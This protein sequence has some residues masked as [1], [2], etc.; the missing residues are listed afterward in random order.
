MKTPIRLLLLS[1]ILLLGSLSACMKK[2]MDTGDLSGDMVRV[3]TFSALIDSTQ[4]A[5]Q[6]TSYSIEGSTIAVAA[7]NY[8]DSFTSDIVL[9]VNGY[10]GRGTYQLDSN[11]NAEACTYQGTPCKVQMGEFTVSQDDSDRLSGSFSMTV[12]SPYGPIQVTNGKFT[13]Y[14]KR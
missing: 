13:Y 9:Q 10:Q 5:A 14:K 8:I 6:N 7:V 1:A 11:L 12:A 2:D 3:N 4:W